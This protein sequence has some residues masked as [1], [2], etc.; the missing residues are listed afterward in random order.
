[1][2]RQLAIESKTPLAVYRRGDRLVL[3]KLRPPTAVEDELDGNRQVCC[4]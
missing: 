2:G 4:I 1:M 3:T